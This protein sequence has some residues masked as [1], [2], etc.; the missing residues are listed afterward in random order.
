MRIAEIARRPALVLG[1]AVLVSAAALYPAS[2]LKIRADVLSLLPEGSPAA[3]DYRV[4]LE[5]FGG[6]EQVFVL[7]QAADA[8]AAATAGE[9]AAALADAAGLLEEVLAES[10]EVAHVRAGL[11][12]RDEEFFLRWVAPRAPL[13][14][15][16]DWLRTVAHRIEP[17][18]IARR[19]AR[20]RAALSTPA[21]AAEALLARADP[22][23]FA[24]S[25]SPAST[26][27]SIPLDPLTSTF[28]SAGGD[29]AL[30]MLT[31]A[32]AEIDPQGGRALAAALDAA[33]AEVRRRLAADGIDTEV[34]FHALGGPLYAAQD[35][36]LLRRDL[37]RTLTASLLTTTLLMLAAFGGWRMPLTVVAPLL[38]G[39]L[40]TAAATGLLRGEVSAV[41]IGF[42][43]VLVGLGI[44][45]G[46]H[47]G[48][49]FRQ[50]YLAEPDAAGAFAATVRG[51]GPPI[52]ISAL[53]TAAGFA[54]LGFAHLPPLRE[55]GLLVAL[56]I[57]A[58]LAAMVTAGGAAWVLVAPRLRPPGPLWGLLGDAGELPAKLAARRP[59]LVLGAAAAATAAA[60]WSVGGLAVD[61]D[62]RNLRPVDHPALV[63]EEL[64][65]G[66]FA[67]GLDTATVVVR[68]DELPAALEA[69]AA[70]AAEL[71]RE[72]PGAAVS[73]P[74]D[75]LR[76]GEPLSGRL[77]ALA[78]LPLGGAA[79]D[80]E[81]E[82]VAANLDPRAFGR[83][84]DALRALGRGEDPGAPP[85]EV[86][87]EWLSR[88][89]ATDAGGAWA[90]VSVRLPPDTWPDGPPPALV[91][92]IRA[93]APG[94]AFAS[95]VAIGAE[96]RALAVADLEVLSLLAI[97][98]IGA[99]VLASF[100][101]RWRASLLAGLPVALGSL[102][103]LGLWAALGRPLDLF[104]LAVLPILLG[105]GVDDGLHVVHGAAADPAAG[106]RGSVAASCRALTLTTLTTCAGFGSL[107]FSR[108]PGL[109]NGGALI[110]VGVLACLLTTLTVLPAIEAV[111]GR[112]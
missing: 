47:G 3:D 75:L 76:L 7:L 49:R 70:A 8:G 44:D 81:R 71:R 80:L 28:R 1:L 32:R 26:A 65:S 31:P 14:I 101:G 4:F 51:V 58:I 24:E 22:L 45:Y 50:Q 102:W 110:A 38:A 54:V 107:V 46:I 95:A 78:G 74:A 103:T 69:A 98:A 96:L 106:L 5:R 66:R 67:V 64:L 108:I 53:T 87:P 11:E 90:A 9:A 94:A 37:E 82:L 17:A 73:S 112:S 79:D 60:A 36:T 111:R 41:S 72:L 33:Y 39:L 68:G 2:R 55:L 86:W 13:L 61:A 97:L 104:S 92:R 10:P 6:L 84:L 29:T 62:V 56:G 19:V 99:V 20:L 52:L 35:E 27:A 89:L 23:G 48:I 18:A 12:P 15:G 59:K 93:A 42:A 88:S 30:V 91:E 100:R 83:G 77:R 57:L 109:Q 105:I 43:A 21:G 16:G 25:L 85:A 63:A 40:W 34:E